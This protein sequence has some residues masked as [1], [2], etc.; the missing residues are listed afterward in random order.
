MR[1]GRPSSRLSP[2]AKT[3]PAQDDNMCAWRALP[4][5]IAVRVRAT[6]ALK[7]KC[8]ARPRRTPG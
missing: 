6:P 7:H 8:R 1:S 4:T 5:G 2:A 3:L